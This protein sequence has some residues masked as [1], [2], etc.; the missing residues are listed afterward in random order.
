MGSSEGLCR[1]HCRIAPLRWEGAGIFFYQLPSLLAE[2]ALGGI[3]HLQL[4][5]LDL[6]NE[7]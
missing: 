1:I 6:S 2:V 5:V 4:A 7:D 3:H